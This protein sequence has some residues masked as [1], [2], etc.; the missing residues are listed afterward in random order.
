M[1]PVGL[2][3]LINS[4]M[5]SC[6]IGIYKADAPRLVEPWFTELVVVSYVLHHG[7]IPS[8]LP[9]PL[10]G[11]PLPRMSPKNIP[12]PA[13][14]LDYIA[15]SWFLLKIESILS[16][17]CMLLQLI[18]N[19]LSVPMFDKTGVAGQSQLFQII[20]KNFCSHFGSE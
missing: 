13:P 7:I 20:S 11:A 1:S 9:L 18:G 5:S 8:D 2:R 16:P 3:I 10:I 4:S 14:F 6:S 17:T 12:T 19:P 15:S